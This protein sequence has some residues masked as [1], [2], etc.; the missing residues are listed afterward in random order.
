MR[1]GRSAISAQV[2]ALVRAALS[3]PGG[4][5]N[6]PLA[7]SFLGIP[8]RLLVPVLRTPVAS[9]PFIRDAMGHVGGRTCFFDERI[10]EGISQGTRQIVILGAG[11]DTR[12]LRLASPGVRFIEVDHP[13]T[14]EHKRA[15]L[16]RA[17]VSNPAVLLPLDFET[18]DLV[19]A[20]RGIGFE[21]DRPC[22]FL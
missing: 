13:S 19:S 16:A 10:C 9:A 18:D 22:F 3:G 11:F 20:L 6:D 14:Q 7:R 1:K 17:G 12:A 15:A 21:T 5:V 8:L 4:P 2:T